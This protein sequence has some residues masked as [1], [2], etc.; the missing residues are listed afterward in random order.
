MIFIYI[1]SQNYCVRFKQIPILLRNV[2]GT[3]QNEVDFWEEI[4][5]S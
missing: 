5:F 4:K 2:R 3:E 1:D